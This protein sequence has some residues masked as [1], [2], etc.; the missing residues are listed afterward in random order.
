MAVFGG[1]TAELGYH[2]LHARFD[3]C[4][5]QRDDVCEL[6]HLG[7]MVCDSQHVPH[8]HPAGTQAGAV[9]GTTALASMISPFFIGRVAD[10]FFATERVLAV[11]HFILAVLLWWVASARTFGAVYGILLAYCLCYFPTL[12]LTNSIT[13][14]HCEEPRP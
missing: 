7:R 14:Q 8:E 2:S 12:A 9:F 4:A 1:H 5:P 10:R 3:P 13:L 11:L 6:R